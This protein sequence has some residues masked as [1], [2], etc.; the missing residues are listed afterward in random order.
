ME[1]QESSG[2]S[3]GGM[4]YRQAELCRTVSGDE[5]ELHAVSGGPLAG[6]CPHV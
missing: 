2:Q 3:E 1:E 6:V 5:V 4:G